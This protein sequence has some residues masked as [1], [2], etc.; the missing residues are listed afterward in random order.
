MSAQRQRLNKTTQ[1]ATATIQSVSICVADLPASCCTGNR[2]QSWSWHDEWDLTSS[3]DQPRSHRRNPLWSHLTMTHLQ[4]D[5]VWQ[6]DGQTDWETDR[7]CHLMISLGF[8]AESFFTQSLLK[9]L[10]NDIPT[11][12]HSVTGGRIDKQIMSS[13]D[14]PRFHYRNLLWSH[15]T[16]T[17]LQ[18]RRYSVTDRQRDRPTETAH[19]SAERFQAASVTLKVVQGHCCCH[20]MTR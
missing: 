18:T 11:D 20:S 1:T 2:R 8:T 6:T 16:T 12:R 13:D 9:S 10:N 5:T 7:Q 19:V 17:H 3:D 4:T 15:S 14:Q